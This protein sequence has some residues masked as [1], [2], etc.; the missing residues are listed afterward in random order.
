MAVPEHHGLLLGRGIYD[1]DEIARLVR[2]KPAEVTT[3]ADRTHPLLIPQDRRVFSFYDLISAAVAAEMRRRQ[4]PLHVVRDARKWLYNEFKVP[5][6]LAHAAGLQKLATVGRSVYFLE[7]A[8]WL[9]AGLGGQRPFDAVVQPLI[10]HL[11]FDD[12]SSMAIRWRPA[13]GVVLDP[14]VQAG[15]PCLADTRLTTE[16][17][18]ELVASGEDVE[19][20][21]GDYDVGAKLVRRALRY[22][23]SLAAA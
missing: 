10:K 1:V 16:L 9:D 15:A 13:D 3:W 11:Q 19:D 4:V 14:A 17:V 8:E 2:R 5:W 12:S 7:G 21:A 20:I 18:A 6:P 23:E 22:E